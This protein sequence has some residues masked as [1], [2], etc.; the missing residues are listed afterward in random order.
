MSDAV[1]AAPAPAAG[2]VAGGGARI[3]LGAYYTLAALTVA[4][5]IAFLDRLLINLVVDPIRADIAISDTQFSL[6]QGAAFAITYTLAMLPIAWASDQFNRKYI[7]IASI[8]VWSAM[9][10]AF[11]LAGGFVALLLLRAGVALGEAGLTPAA[12]SIIR[13]AYPRHRQALAVS[14]MTLGVYLGG[15]ISLSVGGPALAWLQDMH[16]AGGLPGG[17][18]PWRYLFIGAGALGMVSVAMLLFMREPPRGAR[19]P[20]HSASWRAFFVAFWAIRPQAIAFLL[21]FIGVHVVAAAAA[22]WLPALFMRNHGWPPETVG[23]TF[24]VV[25]LAGGTLGAIGGGWMVDRLTARGDDVALLR[26]VRIGAAALTIGTLLTGILPDPVMALAANGLGTVGA[27]VCIGLGGLGFQAMLPAQFSARGMA[28]YVLAIGVIGGSLGPTV[29]P[30]IAK[31]LG[32]GAN[33]G[34]SLALWSGFAALWVLVWIT[35]TMRLTRGRP[36]P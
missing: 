9:T 13:D 30:L 36:A 17:L 4:T 33:V 14:V 7:I 12:V 34:P 28:T 24:G 29:V 25:H 32:D 2:P 23:L 22:A 21:A 15:A 18:S 20:Q 19:A 8:V 1:K 26:V 31:L 5:T 16:D 6:L 27:G 10:V 3:G 11:G 35:W